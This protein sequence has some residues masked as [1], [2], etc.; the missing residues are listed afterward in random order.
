MDVPQNVAIVGI[1][2]RGERTDSRKP[3][4]SDAFSSGV[5]EL[6]QVGFP[7]G[8]C[9]AASVFPRGKR[10]HSESNGAPAY[11]DGVREWCSRLV[12]VLVERGWFYV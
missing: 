4:R 6:I 12:R 9:V 5:I 7:R 3:N 1:F 11:P 8:K 2:L 10:V